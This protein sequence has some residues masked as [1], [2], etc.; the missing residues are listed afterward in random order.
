[1]TGY[2]TSKKGD[3]F[4]VQHGKKGLEIAKVHGTFS[5][6]AFSPIEETALQKMIKEE[7]LTKQ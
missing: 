4:C 5:N 6:R 3:L 2:Y 1:M 7:E